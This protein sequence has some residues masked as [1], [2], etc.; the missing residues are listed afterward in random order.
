MMV[1]F[2]P[3]INVDIV[4]IEHSLVRA[5]EFLGESP[6]VVTTRPGQPV[7]GLTAQCAVHIAYDDATRSRIGQEA[8]R[9]AWAARQGIPVP[10]VVDVRPEWLV[11][12]RAVNDEVTS[13]AAYVA[14]AIRAAR[15]ISS[16]PEPPPS[17][18][19]PVAAHGGGRREGA[20]RLYRVVRSP[21]S[22]AEF[23]TVRAAAAR[24]PR[25]TLAHGDYVL[26]NV[27]FDRSAGTVTIIDW[28]YLTYA[29]PQ[30]DLCMLWPRLT[31]AA[32]RAQLA[33]ELL[34]AAPDRAALGVLH[35]WL[36]VRHLADLVTK[37]APADWDRARIGAAVERVTEARSNARSWG[38][39]MSE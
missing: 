15:T 14:A 16:A 25:D 19:A 38:A 18:R 36:A 10:E 17:L 22:P 9:L 30:F 11:T 26:H 28:E 7:V 24:L 4:E 23:R 39:R 13:G 8:E 20:Q 33:G 2:V 29:P 31:E 12:R 32:D 35:H 1:G 34:S 3:A 5:A 27:L 21:L 37:A 6:R